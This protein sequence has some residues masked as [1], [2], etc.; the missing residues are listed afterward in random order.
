MNSSEESIWSWRDLPLE[1]EVF[2]ISI[3]LGSS[4]FHKLKV[5]AFGT[6]SAHVA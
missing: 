2:L 1:H 6:I 5:L 3:V 4:G